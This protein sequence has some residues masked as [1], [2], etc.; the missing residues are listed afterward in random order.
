MILV[1]AQPIHS[2]G[3]NPGPVRVSLIGMRPILKARI[4]VIP[5]RTA[6]NERTDRKSVV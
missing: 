6:A 5:K 2:H 3:C 4:F 1:A